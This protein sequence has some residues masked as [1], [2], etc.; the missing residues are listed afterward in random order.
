MD[1]T[2]V[3]LGAMRDFASGWTANWSVQTG[4]IINEERLN[5]PGELYLDREQDVP[6]ISVSRQLLRQTPF[7]S[8]ERFLCCYCTVE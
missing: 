8:A 7:G 6:P 2:F 1:G 4:R 3:S 5:I